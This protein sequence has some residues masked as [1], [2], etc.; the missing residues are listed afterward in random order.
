MIVICTGAHLPE[1][2]LFRVEHHD[3]PAWLVLKELDREEGSRRGRIGPVAAGGRRPPSAEAQ[4]LVD[5]AEWLSLLR[6]RA[7]RVASER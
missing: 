3:N 2:F 7:E 6:A 4:G 5:L 1:G